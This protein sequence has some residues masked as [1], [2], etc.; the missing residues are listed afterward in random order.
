[1]HTLTFRRKLIFPSQL[2]KQN[3]KQENK[4][5]VKKKKNEISENETVL[6]PNFHHYYNAT[7]K[8]LLPSLVS[9]VFDMVVLFFLLFCVWILKG[10]T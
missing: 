9:P 4:K 1:M 10:L 5:K 8:D 3:K 7:S 2:H 6:T